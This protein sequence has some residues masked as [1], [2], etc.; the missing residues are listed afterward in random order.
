LAETDQVSRR[1]FVRMAG[2]AIGGLAIGAVGGYSLMPEKTTEI[3][4]PVEV[5]VPA[6]IPARPWEY[7]AL[8][9][10]AVKARAYDAYFVG[11]CAYGT[12][13]GVIGELKKEVGFPYTTIASEISAW[14]KGGV[15]G[16]GL[17]CG[18]IN[19]GAMAINIVT[20]N[21]GP[22]GE[23]VGWYT[24]AEVP[25]YMPA[26]A[27]KV[28]GDIP[29][30]VNGSPLC[31][32]SVSNYTSAADCAENDPIRVER[33]ARMVADTAGKVAEMLNALA[34]GTFVAEFEVP[35]SAVQCLS[36][37]SADGPVNNVFTKMDCTPCHGDP[38]AP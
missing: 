12:F 1:E 31:H 9:V 3:E 16:W 27:V 17:T 22:V 21:L 11:G 15:A 6:D 5:E 26:V 25:Q 28:E 19:G 36:C 18:V 7:K 37:H 38:H 23:L 4:V 24:E 29:T 2:A 14:G 13:E 10:E 8:D 34:A 20:D 30:S 33:C 35:E 32:A